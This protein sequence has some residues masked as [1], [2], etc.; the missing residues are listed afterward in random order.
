[1]ILDQGTG[2]RFSNFYLARALRLFPALFATLIGTLIAGWFILPPANYAGLANSALTAAF[3]ASN[4][5]FYVITDY[6]AGS[7]IDH[8]LLHTWSLA[9]EEQ[10]YLVWP[11]LL[12]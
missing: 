10:F 7:A 9:V 12:I 4:I 2:F 8:P 11:A 1:M 6:F 3:A 5:Y